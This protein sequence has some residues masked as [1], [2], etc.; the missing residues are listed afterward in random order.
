MTLADL[1]IICKTFEVG[2][3]LHLFQQPLGL[4]IGNVQS[5]NASALVN[6]LRRDGA[7][8]QRRTVHFPAGADLATL[9]GTL[10]GLA[11]TVGVRRDPPFAAAE[12]VEV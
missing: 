3:R 1:G 7:S 6:R 11:L 9:R 4:Y 12:T 5:E 2:A 10:D 8:F